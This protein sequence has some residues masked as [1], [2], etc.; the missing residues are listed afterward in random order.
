ML[1]LAAAYPEPTAEFADTPAGHRRVVIRGTLDGPDGVH[2]DVVCEAV[3]SDAEALYVYYYTA[4][5]LNSNSGWRTDAWYEGDP[6][7]ATVARADDAKDEGRRCETVAA[8]LDGG[9]RGPIFL[10]PATP[11]VRAAVV[12]KTIAEAKAG[13]LAAFTQP[14]LL[15]DVPLQE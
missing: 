14:Q 15:G 10:G 3:Y 12:H 2:R 1:V 11:A 7:L 6:A 9:F 8:T 13:R 5:R 4:N